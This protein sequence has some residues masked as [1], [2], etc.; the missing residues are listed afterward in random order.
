M[1]NI[2]GIKSSNIDIEKIYPLQNENYLIVFSDYKND[3]FLL[4]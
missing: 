4:E 2:I 3:A 1:I